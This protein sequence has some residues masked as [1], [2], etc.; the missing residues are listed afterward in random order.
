MASLAVLGALALFS[1]M[2]GAFSH[3]ATFLGVPVLPVY[4]FG[5]WALLV[6]LAWLFSGRPK[7]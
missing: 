5:V 1:P 3:A 2:V 6:V 7:P 4:L